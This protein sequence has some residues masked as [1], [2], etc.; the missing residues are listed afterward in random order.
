[1]LSIQ[2]T[3]ENFLLSSLFRDGQSLN[4]SFLWFSGVVEVPLDLW[5]CGMLATAG[6]SLVLTLVLCVWCLRRRRSKHRRSH[7]QRLARLHA[8]P[9]SL[10]SLAGQQHV[11]DELGQRFASVDSVWY[12]LP[13]KISWSN[14]GPRLMGHLQLPDRKLLV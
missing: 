6:A 13:F 3:F 12:L 2:D 7:S 8:S 11:C 14:A 10:R 5:F 4:I 9:G 1:M